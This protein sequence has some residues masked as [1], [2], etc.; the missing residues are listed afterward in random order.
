MSRA[1]KGKKLRIGLLGVAHS[2]AENYAR[3]VSNMIAPTV[4]LTG[5]YNR[6]ER[7]GQEFARRHK[8]AFIRSKEELLAEVDA[9]IIASET[10]FH[11]ALAKD[12]AR[13][14]K[15]ILCEKPIALTLE[16]SGEVKREIRR[17][18]IKFQM[19][20][21]MRYHTVASVA[22][23]LIDEGRIGKILAM[24]GVNKVNSARTA[25]SWVAERKLSGGGA[26]MDHTVH[27][28]DMMRWYSGSEVKE[29]Y[30][31][32]GRNVT[33]RL[34]VEDVF[35]TTVTFENG[36]LGHIDGSW[37]YPAGYQTWGD[38][39]L[40]VLGSEGTLI[41]D[42]FRQNVYFTGM[43]PPDDKLSWRAYGCDPDT[44][45]IRSFAESIISDK[46]PLASIDDG[47]RG[48]QIT[49]ASYESA[50]LGRA[51]RPRH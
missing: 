41:I 36:V 25:G 38:V 27:L 21:P 20:Y 22:K 48:L 11:H 34:R 45:M 24:V 4:E 9:V 43:N 23:G 51:V 37:S 47:I 16:Q 2:R 39:S 7:S 6:D 12:A 49:L 8:T 46:E 33:Q 18:S 31:E 44:E 14:G 3:S 28:A 19:C 35:L 10:T 32:I 50:R 26:V 42:A 1:G 29:V 15:H 30:C 17:A 13:A 40:E 5:V